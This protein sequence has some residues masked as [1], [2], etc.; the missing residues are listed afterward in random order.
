MREGEKISGPLHPILCLA[1]RQPCPLRTDPPPQD[2][3]KSHLLDLHNFN[4][5]YHPPSPPAMG[6]LA[7][8]SEKQETKPRSI[9]P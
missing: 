6:R 2:L 3:H 8:E 1:Q 7:L 4:V 5:T 9:L